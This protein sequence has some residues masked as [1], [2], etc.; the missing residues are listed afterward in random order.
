MPVTLQDLEKENMILLQ[1][2]WASTL[3]DFYLEK[4]NM[5][6][7]QYLWASTLYCPIGA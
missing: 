6:L 7:L 4:E 2:L 1:Y 5:I 3:Y